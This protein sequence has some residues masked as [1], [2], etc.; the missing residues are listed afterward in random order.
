MNKYIENYS[1]LNI[2]GCELYV[3]SVD[4]G[5]V[6]TDKECTIKAD[7]KLLVHLYAMNVA[8]IVSGNN[9][10]RPIFLTADDTKKYV[11]LTYIKAVTSGEPSVT[12]ATVVVV[13]SSEYTV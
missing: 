1:D 10:Y 3:K 5:F 13:N 2:R 12:T 9:Y 4:D 6:Y 11:S 8:I 7:A